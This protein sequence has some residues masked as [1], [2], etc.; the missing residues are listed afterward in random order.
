MLGEE[1]LEDRIREAQN[2]NKFKTGSIVDREMNMSN[3]G[4]Q[5]DRVNPPRPVRDSD[6]NYETPR[7]KPFQV[8]STADLRRQLQSQ[9]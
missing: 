1:A 6:T 2:Y 8:T 9:S 4:Y 3:S 7:P 5:T